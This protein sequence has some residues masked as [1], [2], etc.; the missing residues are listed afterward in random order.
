[1][2]L[3]ELKTREVRIEFPKQAHA[4]GECGEA[5]EKPKPAGG[6]GPRPR[7]GCQ[8]G[9]SDPRSEY[10]QAQPRNRSHR[11][12]PKRERKASTTKAMAIVRRYPWADPVCTREYANPLARSVLLAKSKPAFKP[13]LSLVRLNRPRNSQPR[14]RSETLPPIT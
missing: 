11:T 7:K 3:N 14:P 12:P 6:H 1:M 9:R 8:S 4:I 10:H 5:R 13:F 2:L